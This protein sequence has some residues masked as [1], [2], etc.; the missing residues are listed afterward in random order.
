MP[1]RSI[2]RLIPLRLF[3]GLVL[4]AASSA[5]RAQDPGIAATTQ[6]PAAPE[7]QFKADSPV[8]R[9][10]IFPFQSGADQRSVGP[11]RTGKPQSEST[12]QDAPIL[13]MAPH[14]EGS[15]YWFSG[16][17]NIIYQGRLPFH[18]LY[19]GPNSFRNS[20]EYKTSLVGTSTPSR[21]TRS[22]R[23]NTDLILDIECAGGR[24][25]SEALGLAGFTNLDV[26]RN[27]NLGPPPISPATRFTKSS[28]SLTAPL[29]TPG[30]FA[31][32]ATVPLRRIE[33]RVGKMTLPDFFDINVSV[34]TATCNS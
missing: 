20:A 23:Y 3:A 15:R 16:Q 18:S 29:T 33:F 12:T 14:P 32:A 6:L 27:P 31:L 2:P 10:A 30:F 34:P 24:G 26:V 1:C 21:P 4:M 5:A 11:L 17:A 25:L 7:P 8:M 19:E 22:I 28:V 9:Q 13:T